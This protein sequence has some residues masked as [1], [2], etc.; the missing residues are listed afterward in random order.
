M[1]EKKTW[2]ALALLAPQLA[3][4]APA[5]D[6][7]TI[8]NAANVIVYRSTSSPINLS[9]PISQALAE[10]YP[11]AHLIWTRDDQACP[12][13]PATSAVNGMPQELRPS[14]RIR[15]SKL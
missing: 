15:A 6:C 1:I 11:G 10:Q 2:L 8:Y 14:E 13:L 12:A 9:R 5:F 4:A 3:L 7:F